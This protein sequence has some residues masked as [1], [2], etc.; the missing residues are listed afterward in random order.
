MIT[1]SGD[2]K[3]YCFKDLSSPPVTPPA[4]DGPDI[5]MTNVEYSFTATT[6]DPQGDSIFYLF[7][8]GDGTNSSWLGPYDSGESANA[9]HSW[10]SAGDYGITVKAKN[11]NDAESDWSAAHTITITEAPILKIQNVTGGL[12]IRTSIK[13]IGNAPATNI[14]WSITLAGK[15]FRGT[16]LSLPVSEEQKISSGIVFGFGKTVVK[17]TATCAE[18][19]DSK[20]LQAF[21]LLIFIIGIH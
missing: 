4:P 19:S 10:A 12:K 17:V 15:T 9:S 2:H 7:N 8:W 20:E 5:G 14:N 21:I 13:N 1:A 11:T 3:V 18:S 6:T 16:I